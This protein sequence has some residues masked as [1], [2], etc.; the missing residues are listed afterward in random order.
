V[1]YLQDGM[2]GGERRLPKG[3]P[4]RSPA[5]RHRDC[6]IDSDAELMGFA[7]LNSSYR[8]ETVGWIERSD[9]HRNR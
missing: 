7:M 2:W 8:A 4:R 1:L 5:D 3:T 9:T 6:G